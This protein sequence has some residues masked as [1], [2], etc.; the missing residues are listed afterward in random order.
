M[1][2]HLGQLLDVSKDA[3]EVLIMSELIEEAFQLDSFSKSLVLTSRE[4]QELLSEPSSR[5]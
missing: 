2:G 1:L 5:D 3:R 4:E